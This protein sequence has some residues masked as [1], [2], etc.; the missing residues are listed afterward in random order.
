MAMVGAVP[1]FYGGAPRGRGGGVILKNAPTAI[2]AV[3]RPQ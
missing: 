1:K 2:S 3:K